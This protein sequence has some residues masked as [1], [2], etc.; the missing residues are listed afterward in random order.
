MKPR[1][2]RR[3]R[4][5]RLLKERL[6]RARRWRRSVRLSR[7]DLRL[8]RRWRRRVRPKRRRFPP[9]PRLPRRGQDRFY[10]GLD[11]PCQVSIPSAPRRASRFPR[12]HARL[13]I[14]FLAF[15]RPGLRSRARLRVRRL[16]LP[17]SPWAAAD[18]CVLLP[19]RILRD[20]LRRVRWC[21]RVRIWLRNWPSG[22]RVPAHPRRRG[23]ECPRGRPV[24]CR[25]GRFTQAPYVPASP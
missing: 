19:N 12:S 1:L 4:P 2:L 5:N 9:S 21:L 8:R 13:R 7:A 16:R 17:D 18:L 20:N 15:R 25:A 11:S 24:P 3:P 14:R 22:L 23:P 6:R 10:P